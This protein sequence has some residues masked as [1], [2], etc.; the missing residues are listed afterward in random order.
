MPPLQEWLDENEETAIR[1]YA[2]WFRTTRYLYEDPDRLLAIIGES[3]KAA[4]GGLL[5]PEATMTALSKFNHFPL[6]E[7]AWKTYFDPDSTTYFG[8]ANEELFTE[9]ANQGQFPKEITWDQ[10]QVG[11]KY[12]NL[13]A[14]RQDLIDIINAPLKGM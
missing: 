9:A 2:V 7:D 6:F 5:T 3:L 4:T 11:D 14:E 10:I 13:L 1:L 12:F 8:T